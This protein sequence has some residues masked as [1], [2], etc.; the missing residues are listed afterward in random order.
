VRIRYAGR[1]RVPAEVRRAAA[2]TGQWIADVPVVAAGR[3][4]LLWY[5]REQSISHDYHR[6]GNL[7]RRAGEPRRPLRRNRRADF[8]LR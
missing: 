5:L 4:E 7:G 1:D 8:D 3:I 6:Y 2:A